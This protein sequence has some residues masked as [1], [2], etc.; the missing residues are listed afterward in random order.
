MYLLQTTCGYE[1]I[2]NLL[3]DRLYSIELYSYVIIKGKILMLERNVLNVRTKNAFIIPT[4]VQN[5]TL[6]DFSNHNNE[7]AINVK[8]T[9]TYGK[10]C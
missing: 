6:L 1:I 2:T 4:P 3:P 5:F 9:Q 7:L 8:W 10:L